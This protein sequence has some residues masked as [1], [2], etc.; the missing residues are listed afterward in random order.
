MLNRSCDNYE[1][2]P[3]NFLVYYMEATLPTSIFDGFIDYNLHLQQNG[4]QL[5][6][7]KTDKIP[8]QIGRTESLTPAQ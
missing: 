1:I 6:R 4:L 7:L 3:L 5:I 2:L 8:Q